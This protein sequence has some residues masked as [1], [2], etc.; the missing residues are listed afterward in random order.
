MG[1]GCNKIKKEYF[2]PRY[3]LNRM[4]KR[5]SFPIHILIRGG[6]YYLFSKANLIELLEKGKIVISNKTIHIV[7]VTDVED[8]N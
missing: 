3:E 4:L 6:V 7:E 2:A 5:D 1:N 8:F